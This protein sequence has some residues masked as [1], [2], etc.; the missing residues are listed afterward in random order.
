MSNLVGSF[1]HMHMHGEADVWLSGHDGYTALHIR[2]NYTQE[3]FRFTLSGM[4]MDRALS[5]LLS[6]LKTVG[7]P[8]VT[9]D[10]KKR[11]WRNRMSGLRF[12]VVVGPDHEFIPTVAESGTSWVELNRG[13]T[14]FTGSLKK[15]RF[16][17]GDM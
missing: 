7:V 14:M 15:V 4:D 12:G 6:A 9:M 2:D 1:V 8:D 13:V 16:H 5:C 3:V 11:S 17:L 10:G